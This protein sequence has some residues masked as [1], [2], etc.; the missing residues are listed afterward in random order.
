[1]RYEERLWQDDVWPLREDVQRDL[2]DFRIDNTTQKLPFFPTPFNMEH[3]LAE[4]NIDGD[5]FRSLLKQSDFDGLSVEDE[6]IGAGQAEIIETVLAQTYARESNYPV[7]SYQMRGT[8]AKSRFSA[9]ASLDNEVRV[10]AEFV[11]P[12]SSPVVGDVETRNGRFTVPSPHFYGSCIFYLSASDTTRWKSDKTHYW[13]EMDEQATPEFFVRIEPFYPRFTQ[14]YHYA[15]THYRNAPDDLPQTSFFNPK[16]FETSMHNVTIRARHG[17]LRRL[18]VSKP[19]YVVDAYT[20]FNEACDAGLID[21]RYNGRIHFVNSVARCYLG[22]MGV[23]NAYLLQPRYDGHDVSFNYAPK[24]L[25]RYNLLTNLDAVHIHTDFAPRTGGDPRA[26]EDNVERVTINLRQ[27]PNE[28]QRTV[29]RDRRYILQGFNEADEYYHPNYQ[30]NPPKEGQKDYRRTLYWNPE[31]KLDS[32]GSA[33]ITFFNNSQKTQICVEANGQAT[34]GD[35]L[36]SGIT[37]IY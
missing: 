3:I 24:Q 20:A 4:R 5:H 15:Q 29:Y 11:Q 16:T 8:I 17:G 35:L 28:G 25:D 34:N 33:H 1:M 2:K 22:D 19:A 14:P 26:I 27:I 12:G 36:Y 18:D 9:P 23:N 21:G 31:L 6:Y 32:N 30:R 37:E 13:I 7:G 10:H